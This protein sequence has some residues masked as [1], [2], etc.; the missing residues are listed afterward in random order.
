M[1]ADAA[2]N[3]DDDDGVAWLHPDG[4]R[5]FERDVAVTGDTELH[6][7][8]TDVGRRRHGNVAN[9]PDAGGVVG[10]VDH[11]GAE[12]GE[13]LS[14]NEQHA[15]HVGVAVAEDVGR[16]VREGIR[17]AHAARSLGRAGRPDIRR[18]AR[19]RV[20]AV[21]AVHEETLVRAAQ[22]ERRVDGAVPGDLRDG[23]DRRRRV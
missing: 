6:E 13:E 7:L 12:H 10:A 3:G 18:G 21:H 4:E 20:K 23:L 22:R 17:V 19:R 15:P 1:R 9:L 2:V 14:A 5:L 11:R 16:V 8:A